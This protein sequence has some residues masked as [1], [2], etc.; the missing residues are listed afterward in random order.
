VP[1]Q[2]TELF[3]PR[4]AR[5]PWLRLRGAVIAGL[6]FLLGCRIAWYGWTQQ[7]R[8]RMHA[9]PYHPPAS[10]LALGA[11]AIITLIAL[12]YVLRGFGKVSAQDDRKIAPAWLTGFSAF[13]LGAAWFDLIGQNF[14]P[15]PVEPFWIALLAALAWAL[16]AFVLFVRWTSRAAW[17]DAHRFAAAFGAT[18]A[19]MVMPYLTVATWP[20]VD[21]IGKVIFDL[22]ALAGFLVLARK[23]RSRTSRV[24][25]DRAA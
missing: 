23:L 3:F 2:V 9:P 15:R 1:V 17:D 4:Q 16:L 24:V 19:C 6:V 20:K 8:P 18:L 25:A 5:A 7:A 11:A 13:V 12:A 22:L 14:L 21:V 10:L